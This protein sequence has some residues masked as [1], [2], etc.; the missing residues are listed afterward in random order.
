MPIGTQGAIKGLTPEQVRSTQTQIILA[1]AYHL[2][3]R[4]GAE[5]VARLGGLHRFFCWDGPILTDSGGYQAFS[6]ADINA[7]DDDG[8][9]FTSIVD[10]AKVHL[11]P[12]RS[13]EVQNHLGADI[14]MALDDC[15]PAV[16]EAGF[17]RRAARLVGRLSEQ[18]R[19][20]Q[21]AA[22]Q[23]QGDAYTDRLRVAHERTA[24][25]L[26]RS[27]AAHSRPE[28]QALFGIVQGG[29]DSALRRAS[30]AAVCEVELPG[31]AVGGVAVGEGPG[32][33]RS[34]V[35]L[36][37]PLLPADK[38][39]YLMGVGYEWD[40]AAAVRAGADMFDCVLP[41]RNGR[42]ACAFTRTGRIRLRNAQ[43]QDDDG[44]IESGCEC[45]TCAAGFSRA[46]LRHLF[47]AREML[48]PILVSLHNIHHF[49]RLML[50]IRQAIR[51]DKWPWLHRLW[52]VLDAAA[53]NEQ[54]PAADGGPDEG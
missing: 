32:L 7:V 9:T 2:M 41:T 46:Y 17:T 53:V 38:P 34:M 37:V 48:G 39:R 3:L 4:P 31:Y 51:Q 29:T 40:I 11:S 21:R 1:N 12:E 18:P 25:W 13:I 19:A 16:D 50:D 20:A 23:L 54:G 52:P 8:V 28:E 5:R 43:Y 33:I 42:N 24:R 26:R 36:T 10:G 45:G 35:E 30:V 15:P 22:P 47:M 14:I 49:Q 27:L 44:V 6:M